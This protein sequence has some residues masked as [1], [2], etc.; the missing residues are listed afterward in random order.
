MLGP[1]RLGNSPDIARP[2]FTSCGVLT[3]LAAASARASGFE[4]RGLVR[5]V[6]A[7]A[8][9]GALLC[10]QLYFLPPF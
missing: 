3:S 10:A 2:S 1:S 4:L 8:V 7:G 5:R 9:S 6:T